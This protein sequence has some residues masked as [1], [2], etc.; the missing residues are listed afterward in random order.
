[1]TIMGP[2]ANLLAVDGGCTTCDAPVSTV[3]RRDGLRRQSR[4]DGDP[5]RPDRAA[6][7]DTLELICRRGHH[8][9]RH[10]RP[11]RRYPCRQ[12]RGVRHP[13][14]GGALYNDGALTVAASAISGNNLV[15]PDSDDGAALLSSRGTAGADRHDDRRQHPAGPGPFAFS[16]ILIEGGTATATNTTITGNHTDDGGAAGTQMAG[17]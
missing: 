2:G 9:S 13:W 11:D 1:M 14:P 16:A 5:E 4:R 10:P 7:L 3:H 15:D 17:R 6:R 8:Q 12:R